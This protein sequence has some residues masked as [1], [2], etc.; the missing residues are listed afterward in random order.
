M[1]NNHK[2]HGE[3]K[4]QLTMQITFISSLDTGEFRIM[5][6]KSDNVE[7]MMGIETDDIINELFESFLKKYQ[8]GLETKMREG[9]NFVFES[10]NLLYYSLHKIS[11][12]TDGSHIDS[13]SWIKNKKATIN[14]KTKDNKRLQDAI[15][16]ALNYKNI[17]N[18]P[19]RISNLKHFS[20]QY[21]WKA[22]EF[23]S[24]SKDWKILNR[25]MKQLP[26]ISYL[27]H[28]ILNK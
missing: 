8:E 20:D 6:S 23:P 12:N 3:W 14:P 26:L 16:A 9:S 27:Y 1:I 7:I 25:T 21:N 15:T 11:L 18:H 22:I 28:T 24:Q 4:I 13:P 2:T 17:N 10:V 5:N 19:E